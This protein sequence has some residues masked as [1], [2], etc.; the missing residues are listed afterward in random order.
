MKYRMIRRA[1]GW[2]IQRRQDNLWHTIAVHRFHWIASLHLWF[3]RER[4]RR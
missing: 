2:C 1:L 3:L 4:A